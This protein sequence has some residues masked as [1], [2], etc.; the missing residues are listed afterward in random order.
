MELQL[1]LDLPTIHDDHH[2]HHDSI[3]CCELWSRGIGFSSSESNKKHVRKK[4]SFEDYAFGQCSLNKTTLPLLVWSG[5]PNEEEEDDSNNGNIHRRN[6]HLSNK[7][8]GEE[9]HLVGWPPIK[10]WRKKEL[11]HHHQYP[12]IIRNH[13]RMMQAT[14]HENQNRREETNSF[15]VKVNM[16]GVTV[17]RKIDLMLYNSYQTLTHTLIT[18]FAKYQD[19]EEDGASYKLT[20]QNEQGDWLLAGHVPWQ[21]FIGTVRRLAILR[22][23]K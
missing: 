4:R 16:E 13:N 11:N 19:F 3:E 1:G 2:N 18:M 7:N 15:Y 8:E 20:F 9:N 5:H 12:T 21:S 22:N 23:E 10:S 14:N 17:G 6:I